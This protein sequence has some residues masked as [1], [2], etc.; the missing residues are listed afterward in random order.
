MNCGRVRSLLSAYLDQE[1]TGAEM[2]AIRQHLP[3]CPTCERERRSLAQVRSLMGAL[4]RPEPPAGFEQALLQRAAPRRTPARS[5]L[6]PSWRLW[7]P[8]L[9]IATSVLVMAGVCLALQKPRPPDAVQARIVPS[10]V[11][12]DEYGTAGPW[13]LEW[14]HSPLYPPVRTLGWRRAGYDGTEYPAITP[15]F[16]RGH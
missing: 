10:P 4:S 5:P 9:A 6:L 13:V 12:P 3:G 8:R 16:Y 14:R 1:L 7:S 11:A 2:L 15:T